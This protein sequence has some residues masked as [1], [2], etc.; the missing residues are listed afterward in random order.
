MTLKVIGSY[1][2][3]SVLLSYLF[4]ACD[5]QSNE[6]N[7]KQK[8][9][10]V[11][12]NPQ[13]VKAGKKL[14]AQNCIFCH[15]ADAIGKPGVAPS[16]TNQDF[17]SISSYKFLYDTIHD[18]RKGTGMPPFK[19]LSEKK[20][21]SVISYLRSYAKLPSRI[22]EVKAQHKSQGDPRLGKLFFQQICSTCH[23]PGGNGYQAGGTGT[24]VGLRGFLDTVSD[25]YLRITIAEGRS[26]TRMYGFKGP[27]AMANL[28]DKEIDD[29]IS[30]LRSYPGEST[31][32]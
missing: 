10:K 21:K 28:S 22:K 14:Y 26:N 12:F 3:A 9:P 15:Q 6:K 8:H 18:G 24:A 4:L 1:L 16:L 32:N 17:L 31:N 27:Q 23:G 30:Y 25:G 19:H 20:I 13:L 29:I 2:V 5:K 11:Q 7:G